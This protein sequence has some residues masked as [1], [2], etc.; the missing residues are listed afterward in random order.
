ML[1]GHFAEIEQGYSIGFAGLEKWSEVDISRRNYRKTVL[2]G[3]VIA[4]IGAVLWPLA[5]WRA[6]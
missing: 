3:S 6:R 4:V 5:A 2:A 1:P